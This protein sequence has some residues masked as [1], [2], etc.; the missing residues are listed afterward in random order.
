MKRPTRASDRPPLE[1]P[2]TCFLGASVERGTATAVVITTGQR[3]YLGG[4]ARAIT[5]HP[6]Q[7]AF[8]KGI[9]RYMVDDLPSWLS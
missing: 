2:N 4:M 5:A 1:H 6:V 8:D 7:T 9:N 3:T